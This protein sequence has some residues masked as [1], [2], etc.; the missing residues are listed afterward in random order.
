MEK[1]SGNLVN[2]PFSL[3]LPDSYEK[4]GVKIPVMFFLLGL[5][6]SLQ[7][8]EEVLLFSNYFRRKA[9]SPTPFAVCAIDGENSWYCDSYRGTVKWEETFIRKFIKQF[10]RDYALS[11]ISC[12]IAG[13]SMGG[14]G[15]LHL[16][17][18]YPHIF[19][20]IAGHSASLR[21][22]N[23]ME[24]ALKKGRKDIIE[25]FDNV[26]YYMHL[27]PINYVMKESHYHQYIWLDCGKDDFH[28]DN[29]LRFFRLSKDSLNHLEFHVYEGEH[30]A[31]YW[32]NRLDT[33]LDYYEEKLHLLWASF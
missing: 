21:F 30:E 26:D 10:F 20:V 5:D 2:I 32:E 15:A 23:E 22:E 17:L 7:E 33:Y 12:G 24:T 16:G 18:K 29:N 27:H 28:I 3:Y 25:A 11:P 8:L 14:F 9:E 31:A 19:Q 13:I 6:F 1:L 4:N